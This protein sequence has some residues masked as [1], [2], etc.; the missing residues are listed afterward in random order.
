MTAENPT[1]EGAALM[2]LQ[3]LRDEL[4]ELNRTL[5]TICAL[6]QCPN[7]RHGFIAMRNLRSH[8]ER[9]G[10]KPDPKRKTKET[11]K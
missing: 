5:G 6:A 7:V 11:K 3:D 1:T 2:V 4:K 8:V 9:F 10:A